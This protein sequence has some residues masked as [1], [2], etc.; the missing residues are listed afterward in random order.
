[1]M[2]SG[3][4]ASEDRWGGA[5]LELWKDLMSQ[6]EGVRLN[7]EKDKVTWVLEKSGW[8]TTKSMYRWF[9]HRGVLNKRL[10]RIWKCRL[11]VKIK[12]FLWQISNNRL[13]TG[14]ELK[15]RNWRG[16]AVCNIC[17][18][19]ETADHI[20]FSCVMAKFVWSCFK[21]ALGWDR[22]P[23]SW[24]DLLDNWIPLGGHIIIPSCSHSRLFCGRF[25]LQETNG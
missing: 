6:L 10:C 20:F 21:E 11:P 25:G 18:T 7:S 16:S 15:K 22:I 1:M 23:A 5:D 24:Q 9:L 17:E 19:S 13:P 8:F 2:E 14:A 12:M 3:T 4:L